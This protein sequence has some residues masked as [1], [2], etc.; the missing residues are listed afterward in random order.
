MIDQQ[1]VQ[2]LLGRAQARTEALTLMG[3]KLA[4]EIETLSPADASS[5]AKL[6]STMVSSISSDIIG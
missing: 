2:I 5:A 6:S 3:W 1:W 4:T